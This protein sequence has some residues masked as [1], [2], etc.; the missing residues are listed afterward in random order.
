MGTTKKK[1][2][3]EFL[4]IKKEPL[5]LPPK[6][7]ELPVPTDEEASVIEIKN[8]EDIIKSNKENNKVYNS[9]SSEN[10][11]TSILKKIK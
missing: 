11:E 10:L 6:F 7:G 8:I 9:S 1:G 2:G 4:V 5:T 3:D